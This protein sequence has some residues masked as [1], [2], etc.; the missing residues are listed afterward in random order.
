MFVK[1]EL[2]QG[3]RMRLRDWR[4]I[5]QGLLFQ[6]LHFNVKEVPRRQSRCS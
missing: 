4:F 3:W 6:T 2:P 1:L 5:N